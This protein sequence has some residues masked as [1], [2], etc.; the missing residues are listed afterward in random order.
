M[1]SSS[2]RNPAYSDGPS[3]LN[4]IAKRLDL[5]LNDEILGVVGARG[6]YAAERGV[7]RH[8]VCDNCSWGIYF[9]ILAIVR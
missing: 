1:S 9:E 3:G 7:A 4:R 5:R 2:V 6:R 8:F